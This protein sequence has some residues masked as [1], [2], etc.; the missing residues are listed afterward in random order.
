MRVCN[1]LGCNKP[2]VHPK[3]GK[4]VYNRHWCSPICKNLDRREAME[5]RRSSVH[6]RKCRTCGRMPPKESVSRVTQ[7]VH[8]L[9]EDLR[10]LHRETLR[11]R[12]ERPEEEITDS[13]SDA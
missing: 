9:N 12:S 3:T 4:P 1:Y 11:L 7:P 13:H 5:A 10:D 2:L 6:G 8:N